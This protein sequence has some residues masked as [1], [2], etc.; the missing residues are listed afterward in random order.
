MAL[1]LKRI[2]KDISYFL[3]KYPNS[4]AIFDEVTSTIIGKYNNVPFTPLH[5]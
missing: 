2:P 3:E 1:R 4:E 5:I